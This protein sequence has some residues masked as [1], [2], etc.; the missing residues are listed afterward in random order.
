MNKIDPFASSNKITLSPF[1]FTNQKVDYF[2]NYVKYECRKENDTSIAI[3]SNSTFNCAMKSYSSLNRNVNV[4]LWIVSSL[5]GNA[6]QYSSNSIE[7]IFYGNPFLIKIQN[8][9]P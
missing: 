7:F 2:T 4:S 1:I 5:T 3:Y 8:H 9:I 6:L